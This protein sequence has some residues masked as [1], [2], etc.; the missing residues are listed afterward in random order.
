MTRGKIHVIKGDPSE[1]LRT[2]VAPEHLP[3][4]Y[5]GTCGTC[6]NSPDCVKQWPLA[7]ALKLLPL[8]ASDVPLTAATIKAGKDVTVKHD[9]KAGQAV[10]WLWQLPD[11]GHDVDFSVTFTPADAAQKPIHVCLAARIISC[12]DLDAQANWRAPCEGTVEIKW[13]NHFSYFSSKRLK[14]WTNVTSARR[15]AI[16]HQGLGADPAVV[17]HQLSAE[18]QATMAAGAAGAAGEVAPAASASS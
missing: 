18:G 10:E 14:Y 16:G 6:P 7:D 1:F 4:E 17:T 2:Q 9:L 15:R 5:G 12:A 3:A 11:S 13:D 8:K